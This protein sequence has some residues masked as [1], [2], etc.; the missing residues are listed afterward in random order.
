MLTRLRLPRSKRRRDGRPAGATHRDTLKR[1]GHDHH[2]LRVIAEP[3]L[4]LEERHRV[5]TVFDL[6]R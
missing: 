1:F 4:G 6:R 3:D 2:P 5:T